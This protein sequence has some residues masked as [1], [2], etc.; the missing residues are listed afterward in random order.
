MPGL[1]LIDTIIVVIMENRSF[2]HMLG[3]LSLPGPGRLAVEG[4]SADPVWLREHAN[5]GVEPFAISAAQA[6][7]DPPHEQATIAL[8]LGRPTTPGGP[9]P[10]NGF[11]ES[12]LKRD[13]AP[14]DKRLVMGYYEAQQVPIFDF[15]ARNFTV[16]D[17][18]FAALP[19]GT[20]ANRLM[21]MGGAT[22]IVDNAPLFLPDQPLVYDWLSEHGISW[23][24]YQAGDF[25]PFFALMPKW[26]D[27]IA[28]SL[29]LDVLVPHAH[30]RFRRF[31]NFARDWTTEQKMPSVIFIEPEYTDGP[32]I[33]PNDDHPPTGVT[34]GQAFL[35]LVYAAVIANPTRWARTVLIVTYD[36]HG[37]FY[38]HV[39]P[40]DIPTS[41]LGHGTTPIF[42]TTGVR[43][44]GLIISPLVD[45]GAV[46]S[47]NLDHTS[48]LQL[49]GEKFGG[50]FYSGYVSNRQPA[51]S[52][53]SGAITR[54]TP[55]SDLPQLP[56]PSVAK[57]AAVQKP[58]RAAGANANAAAFTLAAKKIVADHTGIAIG[59]PGLVASVNA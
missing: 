46:Y 51:L 19:T 11:V 23:C 14:S 20:Q 35:A 17:H 29:A 36:E 27:E 7:E 55:R 52:R 2:D 6:I 38:D 13:P 37:G 24:A 31:A 47:G 59:W 28:T 54:A 45:P 40:L 39:P 30:P 9:C 50:G 32:H 49:I 22:T 25:L 4:L 16:C 10:M 5:G 1:E 8:Q 58:M 26:Q 15:L 12:Y 57:T 41:L 18:W 43:V 53:L 48:I 33:A 56:V 3:Y 42:M 34:P 44:P 21:A